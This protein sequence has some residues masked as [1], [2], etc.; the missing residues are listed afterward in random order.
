VL[1]LVGPAFVAGTAVLAFL[2]FAEVVAATAT[3]S[4]SA[5]IYCARK[6]NMAISL[7]MILLQAG[8]SVGFIL[9]FQRLG[10][11]EM[12]Q[13]AGP[14]IAL[15]LALAMA[16]IA[17]A[18]LLSHLLKAPVSGWR[19]ELVWAAVAAAAAGQLAILLPEWLELSVGIPAILLAF[20]AV[21]WWRGFTPEDRELFK[22]KKSDIEELSLPDP[23]TGGDAPR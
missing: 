9:L 10:W 4:E 22:M 23:S 11:S 8:L 6:R 15:L 5:L 1:G 19:W 21:L 16:A 12:W 13:A 17:K 7:A 14:A 20:G 3:V 18:R 2:L